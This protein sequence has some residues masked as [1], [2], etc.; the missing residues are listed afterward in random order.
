MSEE[1]L[2]GIQET[3]DD[4]KA[5]LMLTSGSN[6]EEA[7]KR[8]L[9]EGS[10]QSKIYDLCDGKTTQEIANVV[11]KSP[12]YVGSNLSLLRRKGLVKTVERDGK[13]VHEQRF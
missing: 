7:K 3:L 2:K 9:K 13:K 8:L 12:E 5:I 1:I 11:Q 4:I 10:E 6:I